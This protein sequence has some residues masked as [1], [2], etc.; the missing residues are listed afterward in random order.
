[1]AFEKFCCDNLICLKTNEPMKNHTSFK[2]GGPADYFVCVKNA[3]QLTAVVKK[4]K[5]LNIP[6]FI[7]GKG[8]NLLV[9]DK[10]IEGVV[11]CLN[12]LC[13]IKASGNR[14]TAGAGVTVANLC[15]AALE[16]SLTGLEFAY[17]IPGTVG[18]GLYMNAGAYGGEMSQVVK[19]ATVLKENGEI[20]VLD[21]SEMNLGYRTS[22]FKT[23]KMIILS[24]EFELSNGNR[25]DI[26]A[27]MENYFAKRKDKQPLEYPSAGSTFK[28]PEG[29]FAGALIENNGLKGFSVGGAKVS[30][31]HA[32]FV[33]NY[34]NATA[35]DVKKLVEE[36]QKIVKEKNNVDLET[37]VVF[38]GREF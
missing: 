2:I 18:G 14:I 28:R 20:A 9:S 17:G 37:E 16:N 5:E 19:K 12:N 15:R 35:N 23:E 1:M 7:L 11:I 4:A 22:I 21:I 3:E 34:D 8:S 30:E 31:K 27:N 6:F 13:E 36:I 24:V 10:G 25:E 38:T 32:G 33:I 29:H 26:K